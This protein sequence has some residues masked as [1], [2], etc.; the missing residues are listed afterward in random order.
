VGRRCFNP[1]SIR[2]AYNL[3]DLVARGMDGRGITVA[4]IDS[5]GSDTMAHD[6]HVYNQAFGLPSMC[7]EE[8]VTCA[9]GMPSFSQLTLQGSP[10]T[11][12]PPAT[13]KSPGLQDKAAWAIE[14]AL[15]VETV[16]AMAP[17]AN[18]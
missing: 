5:Y 3:N 2:A 16:H 18:I 7:G 12:A 15:D 11:K 8:S 4:I 10:A 17:M 6:L 14:V 9:A 13:A 1:A